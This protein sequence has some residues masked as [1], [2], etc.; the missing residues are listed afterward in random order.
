MAP[1]F[2]DRQEILDD[3]DEHFYG[4]DGKFKEREFQKEIYFE[5]VKTS[6]AINRCPVVKGEKT[7]EEAHKDH[8]NGNGKGKD[9]L[10]IKGTMDAGK[11]RTWIIGFILVIAAIAGS[12]AAMTLLG[13]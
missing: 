11:V 10:Q 7:F 1:D 8:K 6:R 9:I 4:H 12:T 5:V 13:A 2:E 3:F